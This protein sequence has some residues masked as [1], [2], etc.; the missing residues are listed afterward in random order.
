MTPFAVFVHSLFSSLQL[1][2]AK[3]A[4]TGVSVFLI[5]LILLGGALVP[6][7]FS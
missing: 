2:P 6:S 7:H 1:C 4:A 3:S 5:V